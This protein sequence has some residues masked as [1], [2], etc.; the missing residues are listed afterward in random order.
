MDQGKIEAYSAKFSIQDATENLGTMVPKNQVTA[1]FQK[2]PKK[3]HAKPLL[4]NFDLRNCA[5]YVRFEGKFFGL[6]AFPGRKRGF[7]GVLFTMVNISN[8]GHDAKMTV[9]PGV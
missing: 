8:S 4:L 3:V 1:Y 2:R 6:S 7:G 9:M 5:L